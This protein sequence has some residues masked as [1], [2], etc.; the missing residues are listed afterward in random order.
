MKHS[1]SLLLFVTLSFAIQA[2]DLETKVDR[3]LRPLVD[4][5]DFYGTVLFAKEGTIELV[6][7]YGY[8]DIERT[9]TSK[10]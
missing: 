8:A 6:K 5:G 7:G 1:L 10:L 9:G 4:S 3:Y 2:Q